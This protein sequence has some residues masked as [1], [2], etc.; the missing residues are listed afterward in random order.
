MARPDWYRGARARCQE[1]RV[2]ELRDIS[3]A[4]VEG[5]EWQMRGMRGKGSDGGR[6]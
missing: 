5:F 3:K 2:G 4:C 6:R 1:A